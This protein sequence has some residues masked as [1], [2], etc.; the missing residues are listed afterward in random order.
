MGCNKMNHI[1]PKSGGSFSCRRSGSAFSEF[2]AGWGGYYKK[3]DPLQELEGG[4]TLGFVT[5]PFSNILSFAMCHVC[6]KLW[7]SSNF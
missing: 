1:L 2:L 5:T 7:P 3:R 4:K 6:I